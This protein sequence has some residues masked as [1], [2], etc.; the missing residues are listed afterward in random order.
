MNSAHKN[1]V[2]ETSHEEKLSFKHRQALASLRLEGIDLCAEALDDI[3]AFDA[4]QL[5]K[6]DVI[7]RAVER[8]QG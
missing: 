1:T 3:L 2:R 7:A 8:A 4:G 6:Q 5:S